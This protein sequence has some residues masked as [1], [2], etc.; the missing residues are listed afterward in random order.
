M[1]IAFD[2]KRLYNNFTG[3]GNH[4]RTTLDMLTTYFPD[5]EYYLYTP[6]IKSCSVTEKYLHDSR[7]TTV[8]PPK[9][10]NGS[11]WRTIGMSNRMSA[12]GIDLFHGLSHE[13]P[14]GMGDIPSV[15]TMHDVAFKQHKQM[16]HCIDR[17]TYDIKWSYSCK[18]ASH[19]IA[20]SECTKQDVIRYYGVDENKIS[21]VYQPVQ[22]L[23]YTPMDKQTARTMVK[24]NFPDIP[25]DYMLYV[26]SVNSRK[27]LLS[28]VKAIEAM[29]KDIQ[30]PLVVVGGGREYK[31]QV[32]RY[33]ESKNL[34]RLFIWQSVK[35][36]YLLQALYSTARVFV[37]PSLYEGFGLPVVEALLSG[38][39]VV[40]SNVSS[41]PEACGPDSLMSSPTDISELRYCIETALTDTEKIATMIE[42]GKNYAMERFSP[43][44]LAG[45][46]MG[47]YKESVK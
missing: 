21:V 26:G 2:A 36:N 9:L 24:D 40:T 29:P 25:A 14:V 34:N 35:D 13:M 19:L 46:L 23:Y 43:E 17:W 33:I 38:C 42:R 15:V 27:N 22:Q 37:Y 16:Y 44:V 12:D 30:I 7:M 39:P 45:Q 31:E 32:L 8:L 3:L 10:C 47:V 1:K 11:L 20:I 6:K 41:L 18:N 5:N 28:A 4:S